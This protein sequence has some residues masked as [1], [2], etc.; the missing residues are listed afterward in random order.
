MALRDFTNDDLNDQICEEA[1]DV[2]ID[3]KVFMFMTLCGWLEMSDHSH[4][5]NNLFILQCLDHSLCR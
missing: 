2:F 3:G 5:L 4:G 1:E